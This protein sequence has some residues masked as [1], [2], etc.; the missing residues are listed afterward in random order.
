MPLEQSSHF[1]TILA[2]TIHDI[3]NSLGAFSGLIQQIK[4]KQK[5]ND[6]NYLDQMEFEAGRINQSLLQLLT[7][8]KIDHAK[9]CLS[10]DESPASAILDEIRA[11][12]YSLLQRKQIELTID[13]SADLRL[14][15]DPLQISNAL[16]TI[17]NNAERSG[18]HSIYLSAEEVQDYVCFSV[19]DDGPGYP[20]KLLEA[21]PNNP[22]TTQ[23]VDG[24]TGLGLYFVAIIAALH[25]N[26]NKTGFI[27]LDNDSRLGGARF[28]LFLP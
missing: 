14:F 6:G 22:Q 16:A 8:Y 19:E 26:A 5:G 3:K 10:I 24:S 21:E 23:W 15:C 4:A 27:Q 28:R 25:S 20:Q 18:C 9:F 11:M 13:C 1:A 7:L 2:S 17:V 12:Q